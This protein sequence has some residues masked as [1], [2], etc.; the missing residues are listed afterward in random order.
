MKKILILILFAGLGISFVGKA[1][2]EDINFEYEDTA[3]KGWLETPLIDTS[4]LELF[5]FFDYF[6]LAQIALDRLLADPNSGWEVYLKTNYDIY[7]SRTAYHEKRVQVDPYGTMDYVL[8]EG[9]YFIQ[10]KFGD[11]LVRVVVKP[12]QAVW[13]Q[14]VYVVGIDYKDEDFTFVQSL[15][16]QL[17]EYVVDKNVYKNAVIQRAPCIKNNHYAAWVFKFME[18]VNDYK[19][20]WKDLIL[21]EPLKQD[22]F[23]NTQGF[24]ESIPMINKFGHKAKRGVVLAGP[25][26]TGKSFLGQILISQILH[27]DLRDKA[28]LVVLTARHLTTIS[29]VEVFFKAAENLSPTILFME[30]IDLL[31]IK[32]RGPEGDSTGNDTN[33]ASIL[34]E[35]LNSI[36]GISENNGLLIVGTTNKE[37]SIDHALLRSGRLGLHFFFGY[38]TYAQRK[39]FFERFGKKKATWDE[40]LDL[41]W[42]AGASEGL[43]GADIIEAIA[44]A[45]QQAYFDNNWEEGKLLLTRSYFEMAFAM[46]S[47]DRFLGTKKSYKEAF[48]KFLSL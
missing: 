33:K 48:D 38:P 40:T 37:Q 15:R 35:F 28:T 11:R 18:N 3:Y 44:L 17:L 39:E 42:L 34:N 26:G 20:T 25:P 7:G 16:S 24:V 12:V 27:K 13:G 9:L 5:E 43:S 47:N 46:V 2:A 31:G 6:Y 21:Q 32:N 4:S 22:S 36:D 30:D 23:D 19:Y 29:A 1:Q 41:E 8:S 10:K 45:K 14:P